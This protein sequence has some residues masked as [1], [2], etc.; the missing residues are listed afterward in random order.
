MRSC[1]TTGDVQAEGGCGDP[2]VG[3]VVPL[4]EGVPAPLAGDA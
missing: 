3:V 2:S 1:E 4:A